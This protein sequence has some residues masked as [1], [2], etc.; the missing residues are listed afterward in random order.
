MHLLDR[1]EIY[2]FHRTRLK[3]WR[4]R[5]AKIL[6]WSDET[7]QSKRFQAIATATNFNDRSVLDLG[8]GFGD[9]FRYLD[10]IYT[11]DSY[12]GIDQHRPFIQTTK[13]RFAQ[14]HLDPSTKT[15][16][17]FIWGDFSQMT[18]K[19]H[20]IVVASGSLNYRSRND[21]YLSSVINQMYQAADK[22]LIFNLLNADVFPP[23]P[24]LVS[25]NKQAIYRYC[26]L[27]CDDV[28]LIDDYAEEDFTIVMRKPVVQCN[29]Y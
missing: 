17:H 28:S 11:L 18:L 7:A 4:G 13:K 24:L 23:Q 3:K 21:D 16:S 15:A 5:N 9:L 26:K 19:P 22:V 6:G 27:Q 1:L 20:D 29:L 12:T 2:L 8:C 14:H 25:Y 10:E